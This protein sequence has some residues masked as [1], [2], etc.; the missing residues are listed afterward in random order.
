MRVLIVEDNP[1]DRLLIT[2]IVKARSHSVESCPDAESAWEL[3]QEERFPLI[4][5]DLWLP[6]MDGMEFAR[7]VRSLP[8]SDQTII[9]VIT[10]VDRREA[11][12]EVLE[13]GANDYVMKPVTGPVLH[14]RL[15]VAE[16]QARD[17]VRRKRVELALALNALRDPVTQLAN[18]TLFLERLE[19]AHRRARRMKEYIFAV[20][21]IRLER[22]GGSEAN[23][24]E[25][26]PD[27]V[28]VELA[29]RLEECV[30]AEDTLARA[31]D[32]DFAVILDGPNDLSD[33]IRVTN[34]IQQSV[35]GSFPSGEG[36]VQLGVTI[37]IAISSTEFGDKEE[38][39]KHSQV[40]LTRARSNGLGNHLIYDPVLHAR[41]A[42][43]MRLEANLRR[44]IHREE[45][46]PR[47]QPLVSLS[48]GEITGFEALT[49][50]D[51]PDRGIVPPGE[52]VP[53]A[54]QTGL[55][56][57]LGWWVLEKALGQLGEWQ[58]S[59]GKDRPLSMSVNVSGKQFAESDIFEQV[60]GRLQSF[61]IQGDAVH[62]EITETAL[63]EN[64]QATLQT[65]RRL[66]ESTVRLHVDDF[67][68][69]Y[70]SLSYLCRFPVDAVKIDRTFVTQMTYSAENMEIVK[71][72]IQLAKNL[73]MGLV[74]EGVE[75]HAQLSHLKDLG[76]DYAQGFLF[77]KP[78]KAQD[79]EALLDQGP[80]R[81]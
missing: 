59:L 57:P 70:S 72:I 6:G 3:V 54:E 33:A 74:A 25:I 81:L 20:L 1:T 46:S 51:D 50:W 67:G 30:R 71:A 27:M 40:A 4:L 63:M 77:G 79:A 47:Y 37:G 76:C 60:S 36:D 62:L 56:I 19:H 7:R 66:K 55:I 21:Y 5:L 61:Q 22:I 12:E 13:A 24:E 29:R 17:I 2:E 9:V 49:Y 68:T 38:I 73:G 80:F 39:L 64:V 44:A 35:S 18:M 43:R 52:F 15:A 28:A 69:G 42:A 34:R 23:P 31:E 65:L 8:G 26:L 48:T 11:L 53:L 10:G 41:A 75:N 14:V 16:R 58:R 45:M 32:A 78:L